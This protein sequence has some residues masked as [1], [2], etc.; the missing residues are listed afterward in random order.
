[1]GGW[2][3]GRHEYATTPTVRQCY[4]LNCNNWTEAIDAPD[5]A[6]A[7]VT[8]NESTTIGAH[9]LNKTD[10]EH[11]DALR[12][13]YTTQPGTDAAREHEYRVEFEYTHPPFGGVRPWFR[14][15]ECDTRRGKLHL[16]RAGA[17]FACRECHNLGYQ[18]S[19]SSGDEVKTAELRYRRAFEKAD[20]DDRRP[21]P[22][23]SPYFPDPPTGMHHSTFE[24]LAAAV[25]QARRE[26][27]E[28]MNQQTAEVLGHFEDV[29]EEFE[30]SPV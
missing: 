5:G 11:A 28:A 27:R 16:P 17:R 10:G 21:H 25:Q 30:D 18:S 19:R 14:C 7:D 4:S 8:W 6:Y 3:S 9:I 13:T 12:L 22:N 26:W 29:A 15:P 20:Q 23:R 24:D 2:G 1:M